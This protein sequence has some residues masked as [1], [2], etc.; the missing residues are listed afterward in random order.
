MVDGL[1]DDLLAKLGRFA[2]ARLEVEGAMSLTIN[3][4]ERA[5]LRARAAGRP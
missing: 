2:E 1:G 5:L 4:R 3:V